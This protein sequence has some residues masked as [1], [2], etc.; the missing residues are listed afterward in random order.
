MLPWQH[1]DIYTDMW[2]WLSQTAQQ[3]ITWPGVRAASCC[4]AAHSSS[5]TSNCGACREF[6]GSRRVSNTRLHNVMHRAAK[7]HAPIYCPS[8]F[9]VSARSAGF[10]YNTV[11]LRVCCESCRSVSTC[12]RSVPELVWTHTR[13]VGPSV[14]YSLSALRRTNNQRFK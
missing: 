1:R 2:G 12:G 5:Q 6:D 8:C 11:T 3:P 7:L 4:S 9:N 14:F 10:I 13:T